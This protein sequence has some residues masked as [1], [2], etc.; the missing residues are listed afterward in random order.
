M[1]AVLGLL[2][3][4][5]QSIGER[6]GA[7]M[8]PMRPYRIRAWLEVDAELPKEIE[9]SIRGDLAAFVESYLG[10]AW[11]FEIAKPPESV[12]TGK[13]P[14]NAKPTGALS[15]SAASAQSSSASATSGDVSSDSA[16]LV[17]PGDDYDKTFRIQIQNETDRAR[18]GRSVILEVQEF[19]S[20]TE[21]WGPT[22]RRSLRLDERLTW[23]VFETVYGQFRPTGIV[24][25]RED[26]EMVLLQIRGFALQS[27]ADALPVVPTGMPFRVYRE[28]RTRGKPPLRTEVPWTYLVYR[29]PAA[30]KLKARCDVASSLRHPLSARTRGA[31][32]LVAIASSVAEGAQ[33][34]VR[35]V[36]SD[37][38][39]RPIVGVEV[40]IRLFDRP[41]TF[42]I[43]STDR[44]GNIVVRTDN[45][46]IAA[47]RPVYL[48][49]GST[50]VSQWAF[51]LVPGDRERIEAAVH[52]EPWLIEL[53]SRIRALQDEIVDTVARRNL[54]NVRLRQLA[55]QNAG[56]EAKKAAS[57]INAL[58]DRD[59]FAEKLAELTRFAE[60]RRQAAKMPIIPAAANRLL[61]QTQS[62]IDEYL[63]QEKV[64]VEV[65]DSKTDAAPVDR[66]SGSPQNTGSERTVSAPPKAPPTP[67]KAADPPK[68]TSRRRE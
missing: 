61:L 7:S 50:T 4:S 8:D 38:E 16:G 35:Y 53:D 23:L 5:Q 42:P 28:F 56:D 20:A 13:L 26:D 68:T 22:A 27:G 14:T 57:E 32:R 29:E 1:L 12:T 25:S 60:E 2:T 47:N 65:A 34:T 59:S 43:G 49:L 67:K 11:Q 48:V 46:P 58:P 64:V 55:E 18:F 9:T 39:P 40:Y 10:R 31:S 63:A 36:T 66:K 62:L 33:T 45:I 52:I 6:P 21:Q 17:V 54:L 51:P 30:D 15:T 19:D 44:D 37:S 3:A 24:S 41:A